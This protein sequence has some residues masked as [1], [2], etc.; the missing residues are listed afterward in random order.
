M[1]EEA[2]A[3]QEIAK[4]TGKAV[5]AAREAGGFVAKYIAGPLEEGVGIF[6]DRLKYMRWER[7]VR[8]MQRADDF[9]RQSGL[10][11]PTR[12]VP[13][14]LAIPIIQGA[15]LEDDDELQDRWARLLVNAANA[16]S[17]KVIHRSFIGI[18]EQLSSLEARI[19]DTMYALSFDDARHAGIST[20][21]LPDSARILVEEDRKTLQQPP[22]YIAIALG[23]LVRL[24]CAKAPGTWGGGESFAS[25]NPTSLGRAFVESCRLAKA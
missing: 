9:M 23:N 20:D 12:P 17:K 25:I 13:L 15:T 4:A 24:G 7:Q 11:A 21:K 8:L 18:L 2:K 14:K 19:L 10:T 16:D 6:H 22:E 5:D 3:I 1:E